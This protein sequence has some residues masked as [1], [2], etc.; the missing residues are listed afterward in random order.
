MGDITDSR[1]LWMKAVLFVVRFGALREA[2]S[3]L[4]R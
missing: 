1:V 4:E 2:A 3:G